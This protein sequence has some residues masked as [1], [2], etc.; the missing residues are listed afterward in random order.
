[1]QLMH[2]SREVKTALELA[3]AALAP[4]DLIDRLA[5]V[6][7]LLDAFTG[8][9]I[10]ETTSLPLIHRTTDRAHQALDAWRIWREKHP[11]AS[12]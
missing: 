2:L 5:V 12:A 4:N 7:G 10:D 1:M 3:I 11:K 6:A 8:L 9:A